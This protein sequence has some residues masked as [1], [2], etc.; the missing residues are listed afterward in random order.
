MFKPKLQ[1]QNKLGLTVT[2]LNYMQFITEIY[3]S[4]HEVTDLTYTDMYN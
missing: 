1:N 3:Q 2:I 4:K